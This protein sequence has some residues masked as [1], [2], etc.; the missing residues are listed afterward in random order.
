M[1]DDATIAVVL[2]DDHQLVRSGLASLV[3]AAPDMTVAGTAS[4][5]RE[6]LELLATVTPDVVLMDLSMPVM[7]GVAATRELL[8]RSP[9]VQVLVLTSFA[10]RA[11][12]REAIDAGAVGYLLKDADPAELLEAIRSV[13]RGESPI[14]PRVARTLL[15]LRTTAVN[16]G[17]TSREQEVL[18][19]VG[20]GKAN[21]QIARALGISERTVK[22]HLTSVFARL[23]VADRTQAALW[24]QSHLT[25][26]SDAG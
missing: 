8:R 19:L 17:L 15:S 2:V 4:D 22:A 13:A 6:A 20:E 7:D 9:S 3:D 10:D 23:G 24:A 26:R 25:P 11:R 16:A 18:A 1:S 14:D 21:K 5:G 12:V